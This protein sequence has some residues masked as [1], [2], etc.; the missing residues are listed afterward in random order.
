MRRWNRLRRA[1]RKTQPKK[2]CDHAF[3]GRTLW[4]S[5]NIDGSICEAV[6]QHH[7]AEMG[8]EAKSLTAIIRMA[9]YACFQAN[10][11]FFAEPPAPIV[12]VMAEFGCGS[13]ESL[14]RLA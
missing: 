3:I 4:D 14:E 2:K 1:V 10:L 13:S 12:R 11:G 9:D 8:T 7:E 6:L 5:W